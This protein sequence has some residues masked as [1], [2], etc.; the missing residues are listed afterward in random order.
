MPNSLDSGRAPRPD[1]PWSVSR[2]MEFLDFRLYWERTVNRKDLVDQFAVSV[3]QATADLARYREARPDNLHYDRSSKSYVVGDEFNA[4]VREP[5]ARQYL[6]RLRL[7]DD[8]ALYPTETWIRTPPCY[9][10]VRLVRRRLD[11]TTLRT[12]LQAIRDQVALRVKYQSMRSGARWRWITPHA[13]VFDG[14]RWHARAWCNDRRSFVDFVMSRIL[15]IG[16]SLTHPLDVHADVEWM[17]HVT[18]RIGAHP[19]LDSAQRETIE[20]DFDM[21]NGELR[22]EARVCLAYYIERQLNLDLDGDVASPERLQITLLNRPEVEA[23][24]RDAE[25]EARRLAA[26]V[27]ATL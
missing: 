5:T 18:L 11:A 10:T 15:E 22:I 14:R 24:R 1:M 13:L 20:R 4:F 9:E 25:D 12:V 21:M 2:R 27:P 8:G 6:S 23:A 26:T 7:L 17:S 16:G 19:G 3:P